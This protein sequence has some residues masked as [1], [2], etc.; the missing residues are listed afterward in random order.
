MS[1]T[2]VSSILRGRTLISEELFGCLTNRI[3]DDAR[4][5]PNL[6][7]RIMDQALAFLGTT[8]QHAGP[9]LSPSRLVDIGWHTFILYTR[10]YSEFCERVA[11]RFIHHVPDD[12][13]GLSTTTDVSV[14]S[15]T[16]AAIA[17][18]GYAVDRD[19]WTLSAANCGPCH[20]DGNCASSGEHG[21]ENTDTR[22]K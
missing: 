21:N 12:T 5:E 18:A 11:G 14:R 1:T 15:R 19:L 17:A 8:A 2:T 10:D 13:P 7:D 22:T 20:E 4:L 9:A 3:A 16:L 6:A